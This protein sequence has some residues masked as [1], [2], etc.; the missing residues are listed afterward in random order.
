MIVYFEV[1]LHRIYCPRCR[2][3]S[4]E[5]L[6]FLSHPNAKITKA[7][8][9]MIIELPPEMRIHVI[10]KYFYLDWH[11]VKACEKRYLKRKFR[12]NIEYPLYIRS[13]LRK[14]LSETQ[15]QHRNCSGKR[16]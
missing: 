15:V 3:L 2:A 10:S 12:P 13:S 11:V 4:V 8:E 14:T 1:E 5:E 9:R 16:F 7:L 6:P